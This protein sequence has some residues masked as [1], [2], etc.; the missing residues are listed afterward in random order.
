[1]KKSKGA[2]KGNITAG[3]QRTCTGTE[4][5]VEEILYVRSRPKL[6]LQSCQELERHDTA[7]AP[8]VN[9]EHS[10]AS[11]CWFQVYRKI[12]TSLA[13]RTGF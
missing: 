13:N 4:G 7:D 12:S 1:M 6:F 3:Y 11:G 2:K 8:S 5:D 9:I 10:H